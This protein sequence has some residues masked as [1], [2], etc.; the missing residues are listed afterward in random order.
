MSTEFTNASGKSPK[1]FEPIGFLEKD[2]FSRGFK[3]IIGV[4]EVGRGCLAGPVTASAVILD[5]E[6]IFGSTDPKVKLIR[7]S[8]S[9]SKSQRSLSQ[10]FISQDFLID[11]SII[12]VP[13]SVIDRQGIQKATF[14][15][16]ER[17]VD[18]LLAKQ[19]VD[20]ILVDGLFK[21][22]GISVEQMCLVKGDSRSFAIASAS[23]FAK[24]HRDLLMSAF[25][26]IYPGYGFSDHVGYGTSKH[27]ASISAKGPTSEHRMSF[28]PLNAIS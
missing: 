18:T 24:N 1:H 11:V 27:I 15:A 21:I 25:D 17:A 10:N 8:K 20:L 7:D 28:A 13:P 6:K 12:D 2:L 26:K 3:R 4:D 19:S 23:I 9:L 16:M 5:L 14:E 22:P